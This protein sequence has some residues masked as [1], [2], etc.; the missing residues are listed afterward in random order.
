MVF[1]TSTKVLLFIKITQGFSSIDSLSVHAL[2]GHSSFLYLKHFLP[3]S[4]K[5]VDF[6]PVNC[7]SCILRKTMNPNIY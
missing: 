5:D 7:E 3:N 1:T 6:S 2:A 4:V